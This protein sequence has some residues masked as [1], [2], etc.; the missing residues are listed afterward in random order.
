MKNKNIIK[1]SLII[2]FA[3][4]LIALFLY[5]KLSENAATTTK[6]P[7][8]ETINTVKDTGAIPTPDNTLA[9][10]TAGSG[11]LA[12]TLNSGTAL[13]EPKRN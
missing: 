13:P 4:V 12:P 10:G 5:S 2:L 1:N 8:S 3:L 9:P 6:K 11:S 7:T